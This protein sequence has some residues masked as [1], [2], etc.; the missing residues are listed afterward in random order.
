MMARRL[1]V[2]K[3]TRRIRIAALRALAVLSLFASAHSAA[4]F[5]QRLLELP[6]CAFPELKL[7]ADFAVLAANAQGR[8]LAFQIDQSGYASTQVDVTVNSPNKPVVLM[9][10]A[11]APNI[12]NISWSKGTKI[13]AVLVNG[14]YR[15]AIAGLDKKVPQIDISFHRTKMDACETPYIPA[16]DE[17]NARARQMFGR[18]VDMLF[19]TKTDQVLV[20]EPL[21]TGTPLVTSN[22]TTPESFHDKNAPLAGAAGLEEAVRKGVLRAATPADVEAWENALVQE[23]SQYDLPPVTR[24]DQAPVLREH[25][26]YNAYVVLKPFTYPGGLYGAHSATFFIPKGQPRPNG[27]PGHSDVYDF[28]APCGESGCFASAASVTLS[29]LPEC[30]FPELKL[31][32]DFAVLAAGTNSGRAL[33]FPIDRSGYKGSQMDI[34]VNSPRKPVVLMLGADE[35]PTIWKISRTTKTKI[36]AV[37]VGGGYRQ[38]VAGLDEN[39]PLID[40]SYHTMKGTCGD[41]SYVSPQ[42]DDED[43]ARVNAWTKKAFGRPIDRVFLARTGEGRLLVGDPL[44]A[45]T[46]LVT[47]SAITPESFHDKDAPLPGIAGLEDAVRKGFLRK[48]T[49]ADAKAWIDAFV[50]AMAQRLS[51][52]DHPP[53]AGEKPPPQPQPSMPSTRNAYVVLKPFAYPPLLGGP[54][55]E[56]AT[57]FIPKGQPNPSGPWGSRSQVFDFNTLTCVGAPECHDSYWR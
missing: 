28:N 47:S 7:P 36:L 27:N 51:Q 48:A 42:E 1:D 37:L 35:Q 10:E 43:L 56:A 57:I 19:R 21:Q 32:A 29:P 23:W 18:P 52:R 14:Y 20:G 30:A 33:D 11:G 6:T 46:R 39:V 41:W 22:E 54:E 17:L 55:E 12:W 34:T 2:M 38:A 31:P 49:Q 50:P 25:H 26:I 40:R 5:P 8:E 9:L 15:Q 3:S 24:A 53:V 16:P 4:S 13:L 45:G 44:Q